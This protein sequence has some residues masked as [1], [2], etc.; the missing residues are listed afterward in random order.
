[1]NKNFKF[2]WIFYKNIYPDLLENGCDTWE[3][4]YNHWIK[5][6]INENRCCSREMMDEKFKNNLLLLK[7]EALFLNSKKFI[8]R[9]NKFNILVRTTSNR[10]NNFKSCISSILNQNYL[11]YKILINYDDLNCKK[12]VNLYNSE[13]VQSIYTNINS[14]KKY[15]FNLYLNKLHDMVEDGWIMYLDDDDMFSHKNVLKTINEYIEENLFIFWKYLKPDKIIFNPTHLAFGG[16]TGC[17]ICFNSKFKHLSKWKDERGSDFTM[18]KNLL[19]N[20][21]LQPFAIPYIL[22]MAN[23]KDKSQGFGK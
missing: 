2:D 5:H 21:E 7:R 13:K 17:A 12:Y 16:I 11:N 15:K 22:T 20:S 8:K 1:M 3:K 23:Y 14:E 6:G 4:G 18:V 10:E 9:E 19:N